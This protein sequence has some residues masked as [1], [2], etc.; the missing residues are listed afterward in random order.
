MPNY[1]RRSLIPGDRAEQ[2]FSFPHGSELFEVERNS[3]EYED[4]DNDPEEEFPDA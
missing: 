3:K 4:P 2:V 1:F